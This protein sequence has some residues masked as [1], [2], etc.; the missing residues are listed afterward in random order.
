MGLRRCPVE[1]CGR[2]IPSED[3]ACRPHWKALPRNLR[4]RISETFHR[5]ENGSATIIELR[6][7]QQVAIDWLNQKFPKLPSA[8]D[9]PEPEEDLGVIEEER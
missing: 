7:V 4:Q 8:L 5:Y 2:S 9:E 1:T 3:F 6:E